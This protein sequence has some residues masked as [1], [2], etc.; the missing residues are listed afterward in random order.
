ML[1]GSLDGRGV[2]RRMDTCVFMA[3]SLPCS[4]ETSTTLLISDTPIQNKV[5]KKL[6]CSLLCT[7]YHCFKSS[8]KKLTIIL[9]QNSKSD[10]R[11]PMNPRTQRFSTVQ[12]KKNYT[13]LV[14]PFW[15][16]LLASVSS[17]TF[18]LTISFLNYCFSNSIQ[19]LSLKSQ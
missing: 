17:N 16:S 14:S 9:Q 2:W 4:P 6:Q 15:L 13:K 11:C 3:E 7:K 10:L 5:K 12:I 19:N 18:F 1:C 8:F